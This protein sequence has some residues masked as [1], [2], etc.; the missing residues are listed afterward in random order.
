MGKTRKTTQPYT[1]KSRFCRRD[2]KIKKKMKLF[3]LCLLVVA[4]F[5]MKGEL[6]EKK[7]TRRSRALVEAVRDFM[8]EERELR[9]AKKRKMAI[10]EADA[11]GNSTTS[12]PAGNSTAPAVNSTA[13]AG[14][15]TSPPGNST[16]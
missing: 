16:A 8:Q 13:P 2:F 10:R 15:S 4:V 5:G 14:N 9:D 6:S 12:A 3:I 7:T 11:A 1:P